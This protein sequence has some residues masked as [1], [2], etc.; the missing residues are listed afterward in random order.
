MKTLI[1]K[2]IFGAYFLVKWTFIH[3]Q[4]KRYESCHWG[5]TF[6]KGTLLSILG[7]NMYILC[8]N[9]YIFGANM[10]ISGANMYI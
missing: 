2:Q 8:A 1:S 3:S 7:T 4:K 5:C 9:M 10:Y 6:T